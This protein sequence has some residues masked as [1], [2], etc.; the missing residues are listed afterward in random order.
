MI[1][2][3]LLT[4]GWCI[5]AWELKKWSRGRLTEFAHVND[6][7]TLLAHFLFTGRWWLNSAWL[8]GAKTCLEEE[9]VVLGECCIVTRAV[10][11]VR[12]RCT[13]LLVGEQRVGSC[14]QND[15]GIFE[16]LTRTKCCQNVLS[17]SSYDCVCYK[18]PRF[19]SFNRVLL[20][21]VLR[22]FTL[23]GM[24]RFTSLSSDLM[25]FHDLVGRGGG[26]TVQLKNPSSNYI[27]FYLVCIISVGFSRGL[28]VVSSSMT[29]NVISQWSSLAIVRLPLVSEVSNFS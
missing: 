4:V 10:T 16:K 11:R 27:Y 26:V 14:V 12:E 17:Y 6:E 13:C 18:N 20:I 22:D 3:P 15:V 5:A 29:L 19:G 9:V 2:P 7:R 28:S 8:E 23:I 1:S 24:W 21:I 25:D